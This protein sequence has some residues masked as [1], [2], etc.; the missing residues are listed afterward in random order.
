[1]DVL[2]GPRAHPATQVVKQADVR[3]ALAP[4]CGIASR[5]AV[6]E[7]N[8][9]FYEPRTD[10]GSSL[11]PPVHAAVA[12][13]LGLMELAMRY[14]RQTAEID[15]GT[16]TVPFER[17]DNKLLLAEQLGVGSADPSQIE[18]IGPSIQEVMF[19]FRA[20]REKLRALRPNRPYGGR[21]RTQN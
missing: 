7:A 12:A 17:S 13:R 19:D 18:V 11:S 16:W 4:A 3:D 8:F 5:R 1:M 6:R 20:L 9:R 21:A 15:L 2:L 14:F 10:Q